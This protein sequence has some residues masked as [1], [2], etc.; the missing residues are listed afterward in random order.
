M[1]EGNDIHDGNKVC[2]IKK[3]EKS[4]EC[5]HGILQRGNDGTCIFRA[6]SIV[7][8]SPTRVVATGFI[9]KTNLSKL[10]GVNNLAPSPSFIET[11]KINLTLFRDSP[12]RGVYTGMSK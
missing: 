7:L 11:P 9:M 6:T 4:W 5:K 1:Y 8:L 10:S 3:H 12:C 2:K